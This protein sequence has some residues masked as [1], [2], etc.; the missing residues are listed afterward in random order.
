MIYVSALEAVKKSDTPTLFIHGAA[1]VMI[2]AKMTERLYE[3]ANCPKEKLII[4]GAGHAQAQDKAPK[5]YYGTIQRF[6]DKYLQE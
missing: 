2:D 3:A 5:A 4:E 6:L 1:D